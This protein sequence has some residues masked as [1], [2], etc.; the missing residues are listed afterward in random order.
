MGIFMN[1]IIG[2]LNATQAKIDGLAQCLLNLCKQATATK[3]DLAKGRGKLVHYG[4]AIPYLSAVP[5]EF[6]RVIEHGAVQ[7]IRWNQVVPVTQRLQRAMEYALTTIALRASDG[8]PMWPIPASSVYRLFLSG[9][10][11][12]LRIAII[13]WDASAAGWGAAIHTDPSKP[14]DIVVGTFSVQDMGEF[15]QPTYREARAGALALQAATQKHDLTGWTVVLRNDCTGALVNLRKG[16]LEC[17][18]IQDQANLCTLLARDLSCELLFLH[19]PGSQLVAERIDGLSRAGV[20]AVQGPTIQPELAN[21]V[22]LVAQSFNWCISVD[23]FASS[24]NKQCP[25]FFSRFAE[26]DSEGEDA[27]AQTDWNAS[28]CPC[29]RIHREVFYAFPPECLIPSFIRKAAADRARGIL[30]VPYCV[31][32]PYWS[33]LKSASLTDGRP[34]SSFKN[35]A[36]LFKFAG[37]FKPLAIALFA[38]DF[39]DRASGSN[40][41]FAPPCGQESGARPRPSKASDRDISDRFLLEDALRRRAAALDASS[42]S[43]GNAPL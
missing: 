26:P 39:D 43:R 33:R 20:C 6:T 36:K 28:A 40:S 23:L 41:H 4:Q 9:R 22:G 15:N 5:T 31:T 34:H 38:L 27:F 18:S 16:C 32:A 29:G 17:D 14:P 37:T 2:R 8:R 12:G 30:I 11:D 13:T 10:T 1:S 25:R 3:T 42:P 21:A 19:A 24:A 35:P 7:P